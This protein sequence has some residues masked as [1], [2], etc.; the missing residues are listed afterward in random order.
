MHYARLIWLKNP[1]SAVALGKSLN[2][3]MSSNDQDHFRRQSVEAL[4]NLSSPLLADTRSKV[5]DSLCDFFFEISE[6]SDEEDN[7]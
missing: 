7:R 6:S 2:A 5:K 1:L 4:Q 3:S